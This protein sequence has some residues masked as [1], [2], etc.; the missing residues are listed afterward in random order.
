MTEQ[1]QSVI[2]STDENF[3]EHIYVA[4]YSLLV[5]N[6]DIPFHIWIS[7]ETPNERFFRHAMELREVHGDVEVTWLPIDGSD[8]ADAP[9]GTYFTTA[10]YYRLL[11]ARLLPETV[12]R[13]L[14]LDGDTI[15]R[16]SIRELLA[17]DL[18]DCV[19]AATPEY[20]HRE[21]WRLPHAVRLGFPAGTPYFNAGV[22]LINLDLWRSLGVESRALEFI[23]HNSSNPSMLEYVDQDVLNSV[24]ARRWRCVGP[25]F[26][27]VEYTIDSQRLDDFDPE[28]QPGGAVP[29]AGPAIVHYAVTPRPWQGGCPHPY[30]LDYWRYRMQTPY[31]DRVQ[32]ARVRLIDFM[33]RGVVPTIRKLPWGEP[34][35]R[36][37]R[38]IVRSVQ[39][40]MKGLVTT[41][42]KQSRSN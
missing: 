26:N 16:G 25:H 42:K 12:S 18:N 23:Q 5:N 39:H 4:M 35:L 9:V 32:L 8:V 6:G 22:M 31:A 10:T 19:L 1:R 17:L 38:A 28:S 41:R 33:R 29:A 30:A 27:Y 15:V 13:V 24:L 3:W 14:Y 37:L 11:I 2:Y 20:V 21:S 36:K 40:L 34:F 7:S